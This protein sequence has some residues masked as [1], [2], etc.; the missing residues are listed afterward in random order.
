MCDD[1]F[2]SR[3]F[4]VKIFRMEPDMEY[5][6]VQAHA[7]EAF[8]QSPQA[9]RIRNKLAPPGR[10]SDQERAGYG[11]NPLFHRRLDR[12]RRAARKIR[13]DHAEGIE[14]A[15]RK[16]H[17]QFIHTTEAAEPCVAQ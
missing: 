7:F 10:V 2:D 17:R 5:S 9:T 13:P 15:V 12:T 8:S 4:R 14:Q 3:P 11:N 16:P 1:V 6:T